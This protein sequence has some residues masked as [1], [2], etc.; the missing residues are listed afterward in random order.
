MAQTGQNSANAAQLLRWSCPEMNKSSYSRTV[1][2]GPGVGRFLF[3]GEQNLEKDV[4]HLRRFQRGLSLKHALSIQ[5][6]MCIVKLIWDRM[7]GMIGDGG[8][9]VVMGQ[10]GLPFTA[11]RVLLGWPSPGWSVG[12]TDTR[13]WH[14]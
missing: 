12:I 10:Y 2:D 7:H 14:G 9:A 5:N 13:G 11:A 1:G 4:D 8:R 6:Y 3:T